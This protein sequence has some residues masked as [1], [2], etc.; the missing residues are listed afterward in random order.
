MA[1]ILVVDDEPQQRQQI[2]RAL[3]QAGHHVELASSGNQALVRLK[4]KRYDLLVTDLMMDD[5]TGF[6]VL[7]WV[8]ENAPGLPV[9]VCSSYAKTEKLKTFLATNLYRI[10][11]KPFHP[12]DL[13]EQAR[14][15]L[16]SG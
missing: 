8:S 5:G 14:E 2:D 4:E 9:I 16:A 12:D 6:E 7:E 3:V 13:A 1:M 11:R 15:L 10:I